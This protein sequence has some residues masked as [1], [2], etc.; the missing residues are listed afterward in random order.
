MN[1]D[2]VMFKSVTNSKTK[3]QV[4]SHSFTALVFTMPALSVWPYCSELCD[5]HYFYVEKICSHKGF[6]YLSVLVNN[7]GLA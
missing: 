2:I 7:F 1:C 5:I 4:E 6:E 3:S